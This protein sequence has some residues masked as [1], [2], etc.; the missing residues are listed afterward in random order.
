MD[1]GNCRLRPFKNEQQK[2]RCDHQGRL[3]DR[4]S[5][6]DDLKGR[7]GAPIPIKYPARDIVKSF[8]S[9]APGGAALTLFQHGLM[10]D[11]RGI[12]TI[13]IPSLVGLPFQP[14]FI[15]EGMPAPA[16][17][18][19]FASTVVGPGRKIVLLSAVTGELNDA[20]PE[21]A[22]AVI[23][24]VL[25]DCTNRSIDIAAFGTQA[26]D[27]ITP[28]G[29]LHGVTPITATPAGVDSMASDLAN[30]TGALG[31][32]GIDSSGAVFVCGP[33]EKTLLDI[34]VGSTKFSNPVLATLGLPPKTVAHLHLPVL[35]PG[36][37][38][39]RLSRRPKSQFYI[40][41]RPHRPT[42]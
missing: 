37:V 41:S 39:H 17:Q 4:C 19:T 9:L 14:I 8:R 42:S 34:K 24:R 15:G 16:V 18:W 38:T 33:R 3:A 22:S 1:A 20:T 32:A 40:L 2:S 29:L 35:L 36:G 21:T 26:D 12:T 10:L 5:G 11:L 25:A 31:N 23:G 28:A 13:R 7:Y 27:G 6:R 30:L